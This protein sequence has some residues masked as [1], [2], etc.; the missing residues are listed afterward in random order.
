M[1]DNREV[2]EGSVDGGRVVAGQSRL[3][4]RVLQHVL[5]ERL[6]H[7]AVYANALHRTRGGEHGGKDAADAVAEDADVIGINKVIPCDRPQRLPV[8]VEL[9]LEI[10]V[11]VRA[12]LTVADARFLDAYCHVAAISERADNP[13]LGTRAAQRLVDAQ[14]PPAGDGEENGIAAPLCRPA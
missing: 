3:A 14:R 10:D 2:A 8:R 12:A 6:D 9:G 11:T 13:A 5:H 1:Q 7:R 4:A